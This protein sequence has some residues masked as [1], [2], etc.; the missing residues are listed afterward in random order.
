MKNSLPIIIS[1]LALGLSIIAVTQS[2]K[3]VD[4]NVG[5]DELEYAN[6][7]SS[8]ESDVSRLEFAVGGAVDDIEERVSSLER[9]ASNNE[10]DISWL[11]SRILN[12][13][14]WQ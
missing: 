3:S 2:I 1:T 6:V 5:V 9:T 10:D 14:L 8:L 7:V 13:E 4:P 12:L 11:E